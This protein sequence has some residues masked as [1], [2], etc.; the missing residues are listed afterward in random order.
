MKIKST[1]LGLAAL[2]LAGM[3][4]AQDGWNFPSDSAQEA[5]ARELN[6]AYTDYMS[7]EQYIEATHPLHWLLVNVPELN[8]SIYQN[9]TKIYDEASKI[10]TDEAQKRVYQDSVMALY[11]KRGEIYNDKAKWI[12]NKAYYAYQYY[13]D[14]KDKIADV[15]ADFDR[16]IELNGGLV[17]TGLYAYY[18][19]AIYRN[20]AYHEAYTPE[21]ILEK[22]NFIQSELDKAEAEGKDVSSAR[23]STEQILAAMELI[24]CDFIENTM[25]PKLAADPTNEALANQIF[26]Y[27]VQYK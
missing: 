7:S 8:P 4:Q 17:T 12:E 20:Y 13:K 14:D 25:G 5:K 19:N 24:D 23:G 22:Y 11:E 16:A 15:V 6:A 18:F 3:V 21:Q 26:N 2:L 1:F 10:T 27:S 9:G